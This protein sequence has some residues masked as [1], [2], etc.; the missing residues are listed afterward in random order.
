MQAIRKTK[1]AIGDFFDDKN[2]GFFL[3]GK[4]NEKLIMQPK[5]MY[6]GAIPSG[7]SIMAYNLIRLTPIATEE[8]FDS[9]CKKQID[10]MY[11]EAQHYPSG[12]AMFL[13]SL[14]DYFEPGENITVVPKKNDDL[15]ILPLCVS[16][17]CF[18][19]VCPESSPEF[20][21]IHDK[22][23]YYICKNHSCLPP[24]NDFQGTFG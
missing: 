7:N 6:D 9:I 22:T 11:G 19:K 13:Y 10:F 1:K 3:Y 20:P 21:M 2:G 18:I 14:F 5:E 23:T 16:N 24:T 15:R 17:D 4:D 12:Y 8:S